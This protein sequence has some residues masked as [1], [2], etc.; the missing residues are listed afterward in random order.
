MVGMGQGRWDKDKVRE[1]KNRKKGGE[2]IKIIGRK[3]KGK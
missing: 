3:K 2:K 1:N